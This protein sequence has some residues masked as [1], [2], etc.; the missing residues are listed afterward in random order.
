VVFGLDGGA[1][2][3]HGVVEEHGDGHGT[4]AAGDG[5]DEGGLFGNRLEVDVA[6]QAVA[7]LAG[8]V[9]DAVDADVDDDGDPDLI[10]AMRDFL[11]RSWRGS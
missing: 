4:D 7:A 2:G 6:D 1:G 9:V 8:G 10:G 11:V 5:G 3:F